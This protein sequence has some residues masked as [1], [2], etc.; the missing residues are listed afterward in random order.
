MPKKQ[1][2]ITR[3]VPL[4]KGDKGKKVKEL[5]TMLNIISKTFINIDGDYGNKTL[6]AVVAFQKAY[7]LKPDGIVGQLTYAKLIEVNRKK[8]RKVTKYK[9]E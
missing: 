8:A 5:Q 2:K 7:K 9:I 6:A 4:K 1:K 3:F